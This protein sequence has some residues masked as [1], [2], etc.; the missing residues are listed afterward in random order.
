[1]FLSKLLTPSLARTSSPS[2]T[3]S[4]TIAIPII[5]IGT[6][7]RGRKGGADEERA[8][9]LA[10]DPNDPEKWCGELFRLPLAPVV[11]VAQK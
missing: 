1:L 7:D 4:E 3:L 8:W 11:Y 6:F 5:P 2:A 10:P 9:P